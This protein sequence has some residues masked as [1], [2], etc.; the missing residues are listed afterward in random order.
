M[1]EVGLVLPVDEL[2]GL[3]Y[4]LGHSWWATAEYPKLLYLW[5]NLLQGIKEGF[6]GGA[7][8]VGDGAQAREQ[9]PVQHLLEVPL[10]DVQHGGPEVEL[11]S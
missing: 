6:K 11:L 10:A 9:T 4:I 1:Y 8:K 2:T 7:A 5:V 3:L